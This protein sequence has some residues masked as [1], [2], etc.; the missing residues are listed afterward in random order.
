MSQKLKQ[1]DVMHMLQASSRYSKILGNK[2]KDFQNGVNVQSTMD[3]AV[4]DTRTIDEKLQDTNYMNR[5]LSKKIYDLF[6]NDTAQSEAY[7]KLVHDE[8]IDPSAI[9]LVYPQ[10]VQLFKGTLAKAGVVFSNT[11]LLIENVQNTGNVTQAASKN[12]QVLQNLDAIYKMLEHEYEKGS[13]S[14]AEGDKGADIIRGME[15]LF[16]MN[17][18]DEVHNNITPGQMQNLKSKAT[19]YISDLI[20]ILKSSEIPSDQK[21]QMLFE[22]LHEI[23]R[24]YNGKL[25]SMTI[26]EIARKAKFAQEKDAAKEERIVVSEQKQ[27]KKAEQQHLSGLDKEL[28]QSH[29]YWNKKV[30]D[31]AKEDARKKMEQLNNQKMVVY[32]NKQ[33]EA[34]EKRKILEEKQALI[35]LEKQFDDEVFQPSQKAKHSAKAYSS[36]AVTRG[37]TTAD[38]AKAK[39]KAD[40]AK[41]AKEMLRLDNLK[42][43][44]ETTQKKAAENRAKVAADKANK[45]KNKK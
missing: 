8:S 36:P 17:N 30:V 20:T 21:P 6:G 41:E 39:A 12:D 25:P 27:Q 35:N 28:T 38:K 9:S 24:V 32:Q 4:T 19:N 14:K 18:I 26:A 29:K 16:N 10:L 22:A 43:K 44:A 40:K 34:A 5:E 42:A 7:L 1:T 13:V 11:K 45:K 23:K 15:D 3:N 37:Q 31:M 33:K 2:M